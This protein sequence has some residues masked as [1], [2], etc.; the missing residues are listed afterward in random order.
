MTREE[1]LAQGH[2]MARMYG[3]DPAHAD[4]YAEGWKAATMQ[5]GGAINELA[6]Q[7]EGQSMVSAA[8]IIARL[9]HYA[10]T[11]CTGPKGKGPCVHSNPP[12][13]IGVTDDDKDTK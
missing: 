2:K 4:L 7:L 9:R 11:G 10:S 8:A 12:P 13:L 3:V 6:D 1:L 5:N